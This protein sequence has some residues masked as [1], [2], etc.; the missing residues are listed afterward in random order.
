MKYYK[1]IQDKNCVGIANSNNFIL[2]QPEIHS[3]TAANEVTGDLVEYKNKFY[4]G[5]W[6]KPMATD[7]TIK[8][9][10]ADIIEITKE[11]Y[12]AFEEAF[13]ENEVIEEETQVEPEY[14]EP[15]VEPEKEGIDFI[16][17]SKIAEMSHQCRKTIEAGIDV[18]LR[19]EMKHFSLDTQDQLN[20]MSLGVMAQTQ[21]MIPYHADGESCIFYTAEEIS[22]IVSAATN[23]KVYHTTY[24]NALKN[25]INSLETI[26]EIAAIEYGTPIPEEYKTEVLKVIEQ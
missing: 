25:Y 6:M 1:I 16:R 24:Y 23:H 12:I 20:L 13:K 10:I 22:Q 11:E 3:F 17:Q 2:Y 7:I 14:I 21:E 18:E 8:Y 15:Y 4:R 9:T 5:L 19:G 26:E